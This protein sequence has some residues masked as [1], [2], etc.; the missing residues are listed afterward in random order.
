MRWLNPAAFAGLA[1]LLVPLIAHLLTRHHARVIP[2]P[3]L[4]FLPRTPL[5]PTRLTRPTDL[6]LLAVRMSIIAAAVLALARPQ[7]AFFGGTRGNGSTAR[8]VLVDTSASM[9]APVGLSSVRDSAQCVAQAIAAH[10]SAAYQEAL[11]ALGD[12]A[13]RDIRIVEGIDQQPA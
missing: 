11:R 12:G 10:D 4:R 6:L 1:L 13:D 3:T 2:F 7:F 8:V 9:R 5:V